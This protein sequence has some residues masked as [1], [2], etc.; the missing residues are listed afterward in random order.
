MK[1]R[2][3]KCLILAVAGAGLLFAWTTQLDAQTTPTTSDSVVV[4]DELVLSVHRSAASVG[5]VA[6]NVTTITREQL[7]ISAAETLQDVLQEVPGLN[8]RFPFNAAVAHP[9]WQAV[10]LRGLGGT[11]AS[12]TLVLI[13]GVPLNDPYFGWVRWSQVPVEAIERIEIVRGGATVS[14]GSQSLAG[15]VHVITR[16]HRE[17]GLSAGARFGS[18]ATIGADAM[19]SFGDSESGGYIAAEYHDSDGY[20]LTAASLRGPVDVPSASDHLAFRGKYETTPSDNLRLFAQGSLF[21]QDKQNA[22]PLRANTT[23]AGHAQVGGV[24]TTDDG[25][26]ATFNAWYQSQD[27]VNSFSAVAAGRTDEQ[28]SISQEVPSS[29][30]G[31]N[32][33]LEKPLGGAHSLT[34]GAD[35]TRATGEASEQYLYNDGDFTRRRDTG[36]DQRLYGLFLQDRLQVSGRLQL[37]FG[38]RL[39]LWQQASGYRRVTNTAE[40]TTLE[41]NSFEDGS[42]SSVSYNAGVLVQAGAGVGLRAST[43]TGLRVPTLNELYKPFRAAGGVVT[44]SNEG[45]AS[46]RIRGYEIGIDFQPS[47]SALLRL[48]AFWARVQDAITDATIQEAI[49]S[50]VIAPCGFVSAGGVCRQRD[51]VGTIQSTGL[52]GELELRPGGRWLIGFSHQFNPTEV[53][54]APGRMDLIGK[55]VQGSPRHRTMLRL[56]HVDPSTLEV[57]ATGKYLGTRFDNDLNTG[58]IEASFLL[59]VRFRRQLTETLS[60]FMTVQNV[61]DVVAELSHDA[62]DFIRVGAPRTLTGGMRL[63][64][65]G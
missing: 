63:R 57:V 9:S 35:M 6:V 2:S 40:A 46:E 8:F 19:A 16:G 34:A 25:T 31:V 4:L 50:G 51:N 12:R 21:D 17:P 26:T 10:T 43:Y 59:D 14:W 29:G 65:G 23:R 7:R 33:V 61:F 15:V 5:E 32:A 36:G 28:P 48:T 53:V 20:V 60:A 37:N 44:A 18:L 47:P 52:E 30:F 49:T 42:G 55:E 13:D 56:G 64:L 62:G 22:T 45:L 38:L 58:K 24:L 3:A 54:E 27:Y 1:P 11:A 39:D 41:D